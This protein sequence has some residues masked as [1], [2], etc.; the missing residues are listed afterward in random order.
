M[1]NGTRASR[2]LWIRLYATR[3]ME[4]RTGGF[5]GGETR[6]HVCRSTIADGMTHY[7]VAVKNTEY[8][9]DLVLC[10]PCGEPYATML[11]LRGDDA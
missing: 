11:A 4:C 3:M 5:R 7:D 1:A 6:C 2:A 9:K 10:I 8:R